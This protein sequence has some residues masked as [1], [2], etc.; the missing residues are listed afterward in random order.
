MV[1]TDRN[2]YWV[3]KS[4]D[5]WLVTTEE[6]TSPSAPLTPSR[7]RNQSPVAPLWKTAANICRDSNAYRTYYDYYVFPPK[8]ME[9]I[10]ATAP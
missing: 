6:S 2:G 4:R 3:S 8:N 5:M 1:I 10:A 9:I 7:N